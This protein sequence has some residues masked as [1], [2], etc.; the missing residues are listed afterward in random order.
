MPWVDCGAVL[1]D[2]ANIGV[3]H[4][5]VFQSQ[6]KDRRGRLP[7]SNQGQTRASSSLKSRIDEGVF[8]S[9]IKDRRGRLDARLCLILSSIWHCQGLHVDAW[10]DVDRLDARLCLILSSIWHYQGLHV[11]ALIDADPSRCKI[12]PYF[13]EYLTLSR[14]SR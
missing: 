14:S 11:D 5:G 13:V 4:E 9:Q 7:V 10:I 12:M 8:Q 6:I 2:V 3:S 1:S